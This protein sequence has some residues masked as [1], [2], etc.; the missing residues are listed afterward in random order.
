[1]CPSEGISTHPKSKAPTTKLNVRLAN[2][3]DLR[4][5][6]LISFKETGLVF[7]K[8]NRF[9]PQGIIE[10]KLDGDCLGPDIHTPLQ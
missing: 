7:Q 1:V 3:R 8:N 4:I 6:L 2:T 9:P 5:I 10:I